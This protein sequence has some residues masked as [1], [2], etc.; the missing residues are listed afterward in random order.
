VACALAS[1]TRPSAHAHTN[2]H[3]GTARTRRYDGDAGVLPHT[4]GQTIYIM[5]LFSRDSDSADADDDDDEQRCDEQRSSELGGE[6][7]RRVTIPSTALRGL[8]MRAALGLQRPDRLARLRRR[9]RKLDHN[10]LV[11]RIDTPSVAYRRKRRRTEEAAD[12]RVTPARVTSVRR[13][14]DAY[15]V[16][17]GVGPASAPP[18]RLSRSIDACRISHP[19]GGAPS[20]RR[21]VVL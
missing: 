4:V 17:I 19:S 10:C 2:A 20:P 14:R 1:R 5:F 8:V 6:A 18:L 15:T 12:A 7:S 9:R 13:V 16:Q 3:S 21:S 11:A